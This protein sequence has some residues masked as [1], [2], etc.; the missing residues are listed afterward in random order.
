MGTRGL[1]LDQHDARLEPLVLRAHFALQLGVFH[2]PA[3]QVD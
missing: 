2:A 3:Q 1:G